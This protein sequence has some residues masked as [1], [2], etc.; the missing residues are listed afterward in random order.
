MLLSWNVHPLLVNVRF[1]IRPPT[2]NALRG[3]TFRT[4]FS[5]IERSSKFCS[6]APTS[7]ITRSRDRTV[8]YHRSKAIHNSLLWRCWS[9]R[10]FR[11]YHHENWRRIFDPFWSKEKIKRDPPL[12]LSQKQ[13]KESLFI[14]FLRLFS[15]NNRQTDHAGVLIKVSLIRY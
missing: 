5:R 13:K 4:W 9:A 1:M 12:V 3:L 11:R 7:G 2:L 14:F 8:I 10:L 15:S 6:V